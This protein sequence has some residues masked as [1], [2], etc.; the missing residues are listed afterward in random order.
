[1]SSPPKAG[2]AVVDMPNQK[3]LRYMTFSEMVRPMT[4]NHDAS[5]VYVNVNGL[6]GFETRRDR[7]RESARA[8][9]SARCSRRD[10]SHGIGMTPDESEIWVADP[11]NNAWQVWDNPGDGRHPVYNASKIMKPRRAWHTAGSP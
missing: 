7:D 10:T 5:L 2:L 9:Q 11:E 1:M 6:I 3:V 8:V 4:Q